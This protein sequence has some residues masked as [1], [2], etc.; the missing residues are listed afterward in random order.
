MIDARDLA[1]WIIDGLARGLNGP[2][3]T[4]GPVEVLTLKGMLDAC[5]K[6]TRSQSKPIWIDSEYLLEQE[7]EPWSDLPLWM[8]EDDQQ[9][10]MAVDC[11]KAI[12]AGLGFRPLVDTVTDIAV[13]DRERGLPP[14]KVGLSPER[15]SAL[16]DDWQEQVV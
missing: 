1:A 7:V 2:Y 16:I 3:N 8:P 11:R 9:G 14:L 12:S 6:G 15:E 4:T 10:L 13:W 5:L